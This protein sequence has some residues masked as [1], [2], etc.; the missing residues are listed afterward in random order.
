MHVMNIEAIVWTSHCQLQTHILCHFTTY[1]QFIPFR[2]GVDSTFK[3]GERFHS[4]IPNPY[5]ETKCWEKH[6]PP[7]PY[8]IIHYP[9]ILIRDNH[10]NVKLNH[11]VWTKY[12][13]N[14]NELINRK[15]TSYKIKSICKHVH[16]NQRVWYQ[17]HC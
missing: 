12:E 3:E 11:Y 17:G 15:S 13:W 14:N 1:N 8:H 4:P 5:Y 10:N 2:K 6:S 7:H 9:K 16:S